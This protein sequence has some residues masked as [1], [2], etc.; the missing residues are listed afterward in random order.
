MEKISD[1]VRIEEEKGS[2]LI[3]ISA[4]HERG[5]QRILVLW[6]LLWSLCG[7]YVASRLFMDLPGK[8]RI[9][10]FIF[11]AF[12]AYFEYMTV[13]TAIWRAYGEERIWVSNGELLYEQAIGKHGRPYRIPIGNIRKVQLVEPDERSFSQHFESSYYVKGRMAVAIEHGD[14]ITRSGEKLSPQEARDLV[15]R[16]KQELAE[17]E[18]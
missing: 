4:Y 15:K 8:E 7:V 11:I 2:T 10:Y 17:D 1:R 13:H 18:R 12:W 9:A 3:C 5:K 14:K 16:L 6:I